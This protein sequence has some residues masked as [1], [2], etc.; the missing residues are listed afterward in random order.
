MNVAQRLERVEKSVKEQDLMN[1]G[2]LFNFPP[3]VR[4]LGMIHIL[5]KDLLTDEG[6]RLAEKV[7]AACGK[8]DYTGEPMPPVDDER[9]RLLHKDFIDTLD[10]ENTELRPYIK[11]PDTLKADLT[12]EVI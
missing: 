4:T 8:A 7:R 2:E 11:S 5:D 10:V 9:L 12:E 6:H 3:H 1:T